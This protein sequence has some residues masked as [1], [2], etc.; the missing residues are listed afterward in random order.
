MRDARRVTKHYHQRHRERSVADVLASEARQSMVLVG[1]D[2]GMDCRVEDS[3][4]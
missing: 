4:Q 1:C 3:S 2:K